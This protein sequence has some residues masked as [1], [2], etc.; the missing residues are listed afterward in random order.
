MANRNNL[1]Q[2][3]PSKR[4][5]IFVA[6]E[7]V[8]Y[9]KTGGLADVIGALPKFIAG[10]GH[11]V[12]VVLPRYGRISREGLHLVAPSL[13]IS[14]G[15]NLKFCSVWQ[16]NQQPVTGLSLYFIDCPEY[17]EREELY[18]DKAGDYKDNAQRFAMLSRA[19]IEFSKRSDEAPDIFHAHDW[20][21]ALV[22]ALLKTEY[23]GDWFFG[24]TCAVF[25][26]HNMGYQG[27]FDSY[28]LPAAGLPVH[29][30]HSAGME[31]YGQVNYLK[32]GI[33]YADAITTVSKKYSQEIQTP[34]Y[35]QGLDGVV[36]ERAADVH[37]ILNGIDYSEWSPAIDPFIAQKYDPK[38]LEGKRDCKR[39]LLR[40]F[41]MPED[42]DRPLIGMISRL[43]DQKGFDLVAQGIQELL[44]TNASFVVLGS[45]DTKYQQ[46]LQRISD[47]QPQR[48]GLRLAFDNKLAHKIEAGADIFL[49]PSR[50]EPCGLNQIYSLKYGTVPVV[51]A[52]GGLDDTVEPFSSTT[53]EGTGFKFDDYTSSALLRSVREALD[54]FGQRET[55]N[56]LMRNGMARD[57]SWTASAERYLQLYE[58]LLSRHA[59]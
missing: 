26:I 19:A 59:D 52:T 2:S 17:F 13:S 9:A 56:R 33:V 38:N 42:L 23:N 45:G 18:G 58:T 5:I 35:G 48:F 24:K 14:M 31:F 57:F 40:E 25:T 22:P 37:G 29:T 55:W 11:T 32:G 51:R 46:L 8:P 6:S 1:K 10:L 44:A 49:M 15:E 7:C 34:E 20:Q 36:R 27:L 43:A 50:Y 39:D 16:A 12:D 41:H 28:A 3:A 47:L 54:A 4:K 21:A 30:F 53:G